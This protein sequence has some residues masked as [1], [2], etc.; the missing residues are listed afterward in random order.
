MAPL[1]NREVAA[2]YCKRSIS[3]KQVKALQEPREAS[4]PARTACKETKGE[5]I[6]SHQWTR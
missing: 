3:I 1:A 5:G 2:A 4:K 6:Q